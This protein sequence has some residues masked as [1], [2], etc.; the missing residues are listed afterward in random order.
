MAAAVARGDLERG[1]C[2]I[3]GTAGSVIAHH[4]DY[5]EPLTVVMLC[6]SCHAR[7]HAEIRRYREKWGGE[8]DL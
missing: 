3:C 7:V 6:R 8:A 2:D 5:A 1:E 4:P